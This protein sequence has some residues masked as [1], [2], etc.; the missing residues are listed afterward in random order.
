MIYTLFNYIYDN[1]LKQPDIEYNY[2][3]D[4]IVIIPNYH[5]HY[6]SNIVDFYDIV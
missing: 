1:F 6:N 3:L 5:Q 4:Y 2:T